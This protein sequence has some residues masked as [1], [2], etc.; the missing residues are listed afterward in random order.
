[1]NLFYMNLFCLHRAHADQSKLENILLISSRISIL[2]SLLFFTEGEYGKHKHLSLM[3]HLTN[4]DTEAKI[5]QD[6]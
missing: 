6:I 2:L 1:M 4:F 3:F 5:C